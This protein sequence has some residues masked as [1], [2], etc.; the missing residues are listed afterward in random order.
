MFIPC[1]SQTPEPWYLKPLSHA[2]CDVQV[3]WH[4]ILGNHD[5]GECWTDESCAEV[6]ARCQG[7]PDCYLSP[8]HQVVVCPV[9]PCYSILTI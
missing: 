2:D 9:C 7:R 5:Y 8:L 1:S 6:T 4:A 3:P